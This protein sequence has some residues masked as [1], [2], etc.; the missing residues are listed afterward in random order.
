MDEDAKRERVRAAGVYTLYRV[1]R[2]VARPWDAE[3]WR[4]PSVEVAI[5]AQEKKKENDERE[6]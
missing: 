1:G 5:D 3:S 6:T 4:V 2:G